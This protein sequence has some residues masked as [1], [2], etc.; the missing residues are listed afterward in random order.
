MRIYGLLIAAF[1]ASSAMAEDQTA[2]AIS[3]PGTLAYVGLGALLPFARDKQDS[4]NHGWRTIEALGMAV[5]LSEA[6]KRFTR[7]PRP[8]TG[9]KDSFP[10]GHTAAAFA[11]AT[12]ESAWHP[13]EAPF[14]YA[15]AAMIANSRL[16]LGRHRIGDL[17]G[18]AALGYLSARVELSQPRGILVRPIVTDEGGFGLMFARKF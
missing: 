2:K 17:L 9:T 7:V 16:N 1:L 13:K 10:S 8:D 18:G 11:I 3:G 12:M 15:G 4:A 5:T 6:L 14:W